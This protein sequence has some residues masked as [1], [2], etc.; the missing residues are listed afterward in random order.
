ML[1]LSFSVVNSNVFDRLDQSSFFNGQETQGKTYFDEAKS[2]LFVKGEK[3][4]INIQEKTTN[5]HKILRY[6]FITNKDNPKDD[7]YF[8]EIAEDEF[9]ELDYKDKQNGWKT[10]H[11]A[12]EYVND[13]IREQTQNQISD[14]LIFN[15]GQKG[16]TKINSKYL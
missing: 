16:K 9:E 5:A 12:C 3:V 7:F 13:K 2:L 4:E 11:R 14:F 6:I 15:T 1:C 8:S 10:Y